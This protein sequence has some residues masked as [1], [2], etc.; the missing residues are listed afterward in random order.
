MKLLAV[1]VLCLVQRTTMAFTIV[2]ENTTNFTIS[3]SECVPT[4]TPLTEH[5]IQIGIQPAVFASSNVASDAGVYFLSGQQSEGPPLTHNTTNCDK[6]CKDMFSNPDAVA[7]YAADNNNDVWWD[8]V[9]VPSCPTTPTFLCVTSPLKRE[10]YNLCIEESC[11]YVPPVTPVTPVTNTTGCISEWTCSSSTCRS[12]P[13]EPHTAQT[14]SCP[15]YSQYTYITSTAQMEKT[16]RVPEF[17]N[18]FG[19]M[20]LLGYVTLGN[21]VRFTISQ[22]DPFMTNLFSQGTYTMRIQLGDPTS[23]ESG[24][25]DAGNKNTFDIIKQYRPW[26]ESTASSYKFD[27]LGTYYIVFTWK[28]EY[29]GS[30]TWG[31][32]FGHVIVVDG[33][34]EM[35]TTRTI[36]TTVDSVSSTTPL[37]T[38]QNLW[39]AIIVQL[40]FTVSTTSDVAVTFNSVKF[41]RAGQPIPI[42]DGGPSRTHGATTTPAWQYIVYNSHCSAIFEHLRACPSQLA[43]E[44]NYT[45][46]AAEFVHVSD[47]VFVTPHESDLLPGTTLSQPGSLTAACS[48]HVCVG[49][50]HHSCP[51]L[52]DGTH[53]CNKDVYTSPADR[54]ETATWTYTHPVITS[55]ISGLSVSE[56]SNSMKYESFKEICGTSPGKTVWFDITFLLSKF[57]GVDVGSSPPYTKL[58]TLK[59]FKFDPYTIS[60]LSTIESTVTWQST[61]PPG[62]RV[63]SFGVDRS[64]IKSMELFKTP[65]TKMT[66]LYDIKTVTVELGAWSEPYTTVTVSVLKIQISITTEDRSAATYSDVYCLSDTSSDNPDSC[67]NK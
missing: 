49:C 53:C 45:I 32:R 57:S 48:D 55:H 56:Q 64:D 59:T 15:I 62:T 67:I 54:Y 22:D 46:H 20:G 39:I 1:F 34:G 41:I 36:T 60:N 10:V 52:V 17:P 65:A 63:W 23:T 14:I 61:H 24:W 11:L 42:T 9:L 35:I 27:T 38:E 44:V 3:C 58:I 43:V 50:N 5:A 19:S 12:I 13:P 8:A 40:N 30:F 7:I 26:A 51:A 33:S 4:A 37:T 18:P 16:F 25:R 21:N 29:T 28:Q 2:M 6:K 31:P 66:V 47:S